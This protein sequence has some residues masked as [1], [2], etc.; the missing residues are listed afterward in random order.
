M[1]SEAI[2]IMRYCQKKGV[3]HVTLTMAMKLAQFS[4]PMEKKFE[5]ISL[6]IADAKAAGGDIWALGYFLEPF[7]A[8]ESTYHKGFPPKTGGMAVIRDILGVR[9]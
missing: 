7:R 4:F 9:S 8:A 6:S 3:R 1:Y 2:E 5:V